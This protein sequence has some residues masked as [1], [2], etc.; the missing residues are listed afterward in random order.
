[1]KVQIQIIGI[2]QNQTKEVDTISE[3]IR[4]L[5]KITLP[6]SCMAIIITRPRPVSVETAT[7]S[8]LQKLVEE[9]KALERKINLL[10]ELDT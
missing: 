10:N 7:P 5:P 3:A 8:N 4:L 1:M 6:S 9:V 2:G